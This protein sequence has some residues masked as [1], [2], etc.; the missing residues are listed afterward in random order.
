MT[1]VADSVSSCSRKF[2]NRR[3]VR[4]SMSWQHLIIPHGDP[5]CFALTQYITLTGW[6]SSMVVEGS[7]DSC[8]AQ[9]LSSP[10][11]LSYLRR[12]ILIDS[13]SIFLSNRCPAVTDTLPLEQKKHRSP[14]LH[15]C[16]TL[17][18]CQNVKDG[19]RLLRIERWKLGYCFHVY[20]AWWLARVHV[21]VVA[22]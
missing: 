8:D 7:A 2:L 15:D 3:S 5:S 14:L 4:R 6:A 22:G 10:E 12:K 20:L 21:L 17:L 18:R 11:Y 1:F 13:G 19:K 16:W 9:A